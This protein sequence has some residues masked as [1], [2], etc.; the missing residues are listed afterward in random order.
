[1]NRSLFIIA[2]LSL[3]GA[4]QAGSPE[5]TV[6][7]DAKDSTAY[8]DRSSV[9]E[10]DGAVRMLRNYDVTVSLGVDPATGMQLYPHR[11][12]KVRYDVDCGA[13]R[14]ALGNWQM[15][16]GNFANG[17]IVWADRHHG[18]PAFTQPGTAEE[19]AAL[20]AACGTQ[21]AAR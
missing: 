14:V 20:A 2:A 13:G 17:E 7:A 8:I 18:L 16:S 3:S 21:T 1:M 6:V 4:V 19:I 9:L 12:A 10:S 15:F 11:S 5:W